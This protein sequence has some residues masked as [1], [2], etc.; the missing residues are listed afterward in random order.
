VSRNTTHSS[1]AKWSQLR[2]RFGMPVTSPDWIALDRYAVAYKI[3]ERTAV[4]ATTTTHI[5][6]ASAH[7]LDHIHDDLVRAGVDRPAVQKLVQECTLLSRVHEAVTGSAS[8]AHSQHRTGDVPA[9]TQGRRQAR[10]TSRSRAPS[11]A[12]LS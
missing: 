8:T 4:N 2:L 7:L 1:F 9:Q 12:A 6:H 5:C 11:H 3:V 10:Q